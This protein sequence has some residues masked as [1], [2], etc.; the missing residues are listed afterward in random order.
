MRHSALYTAMSCI[1][2]C[3][4]AS[5]ALAAMPAQAILDF[6]SPASNFTMDTNPGSPPITVSI[7][8]GR[9][10]GILTGAGITQPIGSHLSHGLTA[11]PNKGQLD[12]EWDFFGSAGQSFTT[13]PVV[14]TNEDVNSDGG[15][16]KELDFSGWA[17]SWNGI[18]AINMGG[19]Q[20]D[21]G[22]SSDGI[23]LTD[24]PPPTS[25]IDIANIETP[26]GSGI[27]VPYENG[28]ARAT[29]VCTIADC[30]FGSNFT[31]T[32]TAIVPQADPSNFGG[33]TY[34]VNLTG[35]ILDPNA[36][37]IANSDTSASITNNPVIVDVVDNDAQNPN[38][39][40]LLPVTPTVQG[41]SAVTVVTDSKNPGYTEVTYTPPIGFT[42]TDTFTY[43]VGNASGTSNAATVTVNVAANVAPAAVD[44]TLT[45]NTAALD[46]AGGFIDLDIL[47]NDIDANNPV[48]LTGGIN[49]AS[50]QIVANAT[51]GNCTVN[52]DG[53]IR[54]TQ[55]VSS[56]ATSST[57]EF[58]TYQVS[59]IDIDT[60][61]AGP[62]T[63]NIAK[64][65]IEV[66]AIESDWPL[67]LTANT[68]PILFYEAGVPGINVNIKP[69][70]GSFFTMQV[71]TGVLVYT[72]L[73][74]GP[75]GGM[76]IGY[77]QPTGNSHGSEPFGIEESGLDEPWLFFNNTGFTF[78][79]NGGIIGNPDGT[80]Q[81]GSGMVGQQGRYIITWNGIPEIDL[82]GSPA[83][84][85]DLGFGS[86]NCDTAQP[87]DPSKTASCADTNFF[88]LKYA[89]HVPPNDPSQFSNVPYTL[90]LTGTVGFLDG[91]FASNTG[92][93]IA[94]EDRMAATDT[95]TNDLDVITQCA[96]S[97]ID[98]TITGVTPGGQ[99]K[100]VV[101]LTSG[102]PRNPVWRI[103]DKGVWRNFDTSQGDAIKTAAWAP[104]DGACPAAGDPAYQTSATGLAVTGDLCAE[105]TITDNDGTNSAVAVNDLDPTAGT[106]ATISGFGSGGSA[107][108]VAPVS[109]TLRK[110]DN[111]G[112]SLVTDSIKPQTRGEWWLLAGFITWLGLRRKKQQH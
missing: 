25:P 83:F 57:T 77:D 55:P 102:V 9:D 95:G 56:I 41:G 19:G 104:G 33:V 109:I 8:P 31:L 86:I 100:L 39:T 48:G 52:P 35:V 85:E 53:S 68:I 5:E 111:S 21:C 50:V 76:T 84:A 42:G 38:S 103:L 29:L 82:G 3:A 47:N 1:L 30:P 10:G 36:K 58:C 46:N 40:T 13:S 15:F 12:Q 96:T 11:H 26:T 79:K 37:P 105:L 24:P 97:C 92:T 45:T 73:T 60:S 88:S 101:P 6:T 98:S 94:N 23:C 51:I 112:C 80:L 17:V 14:V 71:Q 78:T 16:T 89:A 43:T 93:T 49:P 81:F 62:L 106:V 108:G 18:P 32:Y 75:Y 64:L 74:P 63:S 87:V 34:G 22:T 59:D 66:S 70:T 69:Q 67:A 27:F 44:D 65:G 4:P 28:T 61:G 2:A 107:S 54:Y 91:D 110:G 20:Q 7:L 99:M 72:T 90:T